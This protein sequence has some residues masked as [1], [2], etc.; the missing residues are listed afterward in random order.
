MTTPR[1]IVTLLTKYDHHYHTVGEPLVTD[2]EYDKLKET[3]REMQPKHVYFRRVGADIDNSIKLPYYM[4]SLDKIKNDPQEINKWCKK[5]KTSP[6]IIT[7]KL[8]GVS[9]LIVSDSLSSK[10]K[11][12]VMTRGNGTEGKDI[13]YIRDIV[14]GIPIKL[15]EAVAIRGELIIRKGDFKAEYGSNARNVVAGLVNAKVLRKDLLNIVHFVAYSIVE[16]R[17][18]PMLEQIKLMENEG[19]EVVPNY[20]FPSLNVDILC[21]HLKTRKEEG[22]YEMDGLV[23]TDNGAGYILG[24]SP[25]NPKHAFAFKN[26]LTHEERSVIVKH[27]EWN[28][29]KDGYMKP[30]VIFETPVSLDGVTISVA[31]GH[32]AKFI[33]DNR[34]GKGAVIVIIRSGGVIPKIVRVEKGSDVDMFPPEHVYKWNASGVDILNVSDSSVD[35]TSLT[36]M[37]YFFKSLSIKNIAE[38]TIHRLYNANYKSIIDLLQVKDANDLC[39]IEGI[40]VK[41]AKYILDVVK[42]VPCKPLRDLMVASGMFGRG[43]GEV[44][45]GLILSVIP[46]RDITD[47][48]ELVTFERLTSIDRIGKENAKLFIGGLSSFKEFYKELRSFVKDTQLETTPKNKKDDTTHRRNTLFSDIKVVFSGFRDKTWKTLIEEGGGE[49]QNN[50]TSKTTLVVSDNTDTTKIQ[51]AREKGIEIISKDAFGK[52]LHAVT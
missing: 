22:L 9:C 48:I 23:V 21:N 44:K 28:T 35:T 15:K 6:Y 1:D 16:P 40:D 52:R 25:K 11:I 32:N 18:I 42:E 30:R 38:K 10:S 37:V 47:R 14:K 3:L 5:F 41:T 49:V 46:E 31:T 4:G 24:D 12:R 51:L 29:S 20:S 7:D 45:I 13:S 17:G 26:S 50:I 8:D 36:K 39:G 27:V 2:D 43:L 33:K 34:I 19:L